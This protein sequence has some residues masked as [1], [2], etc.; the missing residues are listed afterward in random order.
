MEDFSEYDNFRILKHKGGTTHEKAASPA[1]VGGAANVTNQRLDL[2]LTV[3]HF[4][5]SPIHDF[6]S[7]CKIIA[8]KR[9]LDG[10]VGFWAGRKYLN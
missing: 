3:L 4:D 8:V 5:F 2:T 6:S 10:Y 9:N 1:L 7:Y